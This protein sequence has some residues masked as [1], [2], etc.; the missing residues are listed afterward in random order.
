MFDIIRDAVIHRRLEMIRQD[1][2]TAGQ[3]LEHLIRRPE[4]IET[5]DGKSVWTLLHGLEAALYVAAATLRAVR[6]ETQGASA[7][8]VQRALRD[9]EA[10]V[11]S[12]RQVMDEA[13]LPYAAKHFPPPPVETRWDIKPP[14]H[15]P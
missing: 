6:R 14:E 4:A 8:A 3:S 11:V 13:I 12:V 10:A 7:P 2:L 1:L 5:M 9:M 15:L